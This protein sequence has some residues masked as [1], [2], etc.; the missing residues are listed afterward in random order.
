MLLVAN[1]VWL[2]FKLLPEGKKRNRSE[3]SANIVHKIKLKK[4]NQ[5]ERQ[6]H[7]KKN[8]RERGGSVLYKSKQPSQTERL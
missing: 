8:A 6:K 2:P 3:I 5:T 4:P 1:E 7:R